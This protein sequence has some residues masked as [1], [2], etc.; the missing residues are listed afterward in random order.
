M[1]SRRDRNIIAC[2]RIICL[3]FLSATSIIAQVDR[4][5]P[6]EPLPSPGWSFG[7]NERFTLSNG[8]KVIFVPSTV[9][10]M[11]AHLQVAGG[12]SADGEKHGLA[13]MVRVMLDHGTTLR[14]V[15]KIIRTRESLGILTFFSSDVRSIDIGTIGLREYSDSL[16]DIFSD[17]IMHPMFPDGEWNVIKKWYGTGLRRQDNASQQALFCF[18]SL[19]Y[20]NSPYGHTMTVDDMN[21]ITTADLREFHRT[22][23]VPSNATLVIIGDFSID[24]LKRKL[25]SV[26]GEWKQAAVPSIPVP[27]FPA[28]QG[29]RVILV[30]RPASVQSSIRIVRRLPLP[31]REDRQRSIILEKILGGRSSG[32]L[33]M[34]LRELHGYTYGAYCLFGGDAFSEQFIAYADVRNAVTDSAITEMLSEITKVGTVPVSEDQLRRAVQQVEGEF[35]MSIS[36]SIGL[37]D[38]LLYLSRNNLPE[39]Y[40]QSMLDINRTITPADLMDLA[41]RYLNPD[42]LAIIV[43][44]N[45]SEIRPKLEKFGSVEI[46]KADVGESQAGLK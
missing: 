27:V 22:Y 34:N 33:F 5:H 23:F 8:L 15:H 37:A 18:D 32:R 19:L 41:H 11:M 16:L 31:D 46:W 9:P 39:G 17:E 2:L 21:R 25:E 20:G 36:Q 42:D 44:G 14:S 6:P 30:D 3:M 12:E 1:K 35:Y 10:L 13:D 26:F 38:K 7:H 29:R 45:A 24:E 28:W 40:F 43:V 4:S